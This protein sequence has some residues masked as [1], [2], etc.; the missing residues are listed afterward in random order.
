MAPDGHHDNAVR[1]KAARA[2]G[3]VGKA[4]SVLDQVAA[5]GRPVRFAELLAE[6]PFP[7][8][9]LYRLL[10]T[11]SAEGMLIYEESSQTYSVGLRL[12]RMAHAAWQQN[13]LAPVA[14]PFLDALSAELGETLHLAQLDQ[15]QVYYVDKR[16]AARPID[17]YAEAGKVGP[18]YCTG[19]GKAMLAFTP[20]PALSDA[21][22]KQSYHRFTDKT[23]TTPDSLRA[24]LDEIRAR[25]YAVDDEEHEPG[26]ICAAVPVLAADGRPI[27]ALSVTS[28]T[29]RTTL[30]AL[31]D[32]V[33]QLT[34]T[35]D[36]I[37]EAASAWRFPGAGSPN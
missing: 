15:G 28:S 4:L 12:M 9:T 14:A 11:L 17:M 1:E 29:A 37:A 20:E 8:A 25:G 10:Q 6:S 33:P 30:S 16:N 36:R 5:H 13:S 18:A 24:A 2:T 32:L 3:T 35:A 21:L 31:I 22:S 7:K 26:I 23:L 27:G 34:E 19:V